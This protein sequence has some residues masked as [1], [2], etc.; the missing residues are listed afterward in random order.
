MAVRW[1]FTSKPDENPRALTAAGARVHIGERK[2]KRPKPQEWQTRAWDFYDDLGEIKFGYGNFGNALSQVRFYVGV[3]MDA[4]EAPV[5]VQDVLAGVT[6]G[7]YTTDEI[8]PG[9][10][11]QT[12][13]L[14]VELLRRVRSP[15][16]GQ[17]TIVREMA[18]NL[19]IAGECYLLARTVDD[20][21]TWDV[22]SVDELRSKGGGRWEIVTGPGKGEELDPESTFLARVW[23]PH[24]RRSS[25]ADSNMRGVLDRCEELMLLQQG[26]M[27]IAQ[28]RIA[29]TGVMYVSN[30]LNPIGPVKPAAPDGA[31]S[32]P[33]FETLV[34]SWMAAISTPGDA[35]AVVPPIVRGDGP[36]DDRIAWVFEPRALGNVELERQDALVR[37]I[38]QGIDMAPERLLGL[39]DTSTYANALLVTQDEFNT[40]HKPTALLI[41]DALTSTW[42]QPGLIEALSTAGW[43]ADRIDAL[44]SRL[45]VWYDPSDLV[46]E[47]EAKDDTKWAYEHGLL[48]DAAAAT[49]FGIDAEEQ[50]DDDELQRRSDQGRLG[51]TPQQGGGTL[52][53]PITEQNARRAIAAAAT[54]STNVQRR[55]DVLAARLASIDH[56]LGARL[57]AECGH[58]VDDALRVAGSRLRSSAQSNAHL[59][60]A[61]RGVPA[62]QVGTTVGASVARALGVTDDTLLDGSFDDLAD[63]YDDLVRRAQEATLA[64]LTRAGAEFTELQLEEARRQYDD[65]RRDGWALLLGGL[66]ALAGA[67]IFSPTLVEPAAGEFDPTLSVAPGLI[68]QSMAVAG[69]ATAGAEVGPAG[70]APLVAMGTQPAGGVATGTTADGLLRTVLRARLVGWTWEHAA[71]GEPGRPFEPHAELDG[72]SF[73]SWQSDVLANDQGWPDVAYFYPGD[74]D[75][76]TC[77]FGPRLGPDE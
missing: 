48:S 21:E 7:R 69:G 23:R 3:L 54:P 59:R 22:L 6:S 15:L 55:L 74:H 63:T 70:G 53:T 49:R 20:V 57:I 77:G 56:A 75:Y 68:R 14:A 34:E 5:P 62:H 65:D 40:S 35:A 19:G 60:T 66:V 24:P 50:P 64:A 43:S 44:V 10:T 26:N 1:P 46:S 2:V 71:M 52:P 76:C 39:G 42:E 17:S 47:P 32:D 73:D 29:N 16:G 45:V 41:A 36:L 8:P 30:D 37:R 11:D 67:R 9:L 72:V 31:Q 51:R 38:A 61:L 28:S 13:A 27:A 33:F 25:L 4:D 12:A 58:A 18:I